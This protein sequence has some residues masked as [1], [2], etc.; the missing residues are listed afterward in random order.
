MIHVTWI[1]EGILAHSFYPFVGDLDEIYT[2]GIRAIV[3]MEK[4]SN[5]DLTII[6]KKNFD[7]LEITVKDF[8][9]PTL[10]QL[11][12][13]NTF[14]D[15]KKEE[16]KPVLVHCF[17]AGRSGTVLASHLI[18]L[19]ESP[20]NAVQE[21]RNRIT[22]NT[23]IPYKGIIETEDQRRILDYYAMEQKKQ[24]SLDV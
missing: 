11:I 6:Q 18:H 9:A 16:G 3:S 13:I 12:Q 24:G 8:T 20:E 4:R 10:E 14:I 15:K 7:Y 1:I 22:Q 17:V 19:G 21:I 23:G 5:F 2:K